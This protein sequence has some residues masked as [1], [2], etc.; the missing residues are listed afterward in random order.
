M[1]V[2]IQKSLCG[3]IKIDILIESKCFYLKISRVHVFCLNFSQVCM[4]CNDDH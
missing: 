1:D 3:V 4:F 2:E